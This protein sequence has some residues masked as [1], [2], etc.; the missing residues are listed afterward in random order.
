MR[1][2]ARVRR[3]QAVCLVLAG[4]LAGCVSTQSPQAPGPRS[5]VAREDPLVL[6]AQG[7]LRLASGEIAAGLRLLRRAW[8]LDPDSAE[9]GEELGL[10]LM[11]SG[12]TGDALAVLKSLPARS[13]A[14]EAALGILLVGEATTLDQTQAAVGHLRAGVDAFPMGSQA[15]LTL[16]QALVRL[17]QGEEASEHVRRLL[18]ERPGDPRLHLL[19]GQ[20]LRLQGK[21]EQAIEWYEKA[22]ANPEIRI[23]A[24][25]ELIDAYSATGQFAKAA[26]LMGAFLREGSPTLGALTR[27]ATLLARSG[28]REKAVE[29]VDEVIDKDPNFREGLLLKALFEL[30]DNRMESAERLYRRA[31][32]LDPGDPDARLG[33]GRLL[34]ELRRLD[35]ARTE[36]QKVW[37][38]VS[39]ASGVPSEALADLTRDLAALELTARRPDSARVWLEKSSEGSIGRRALALWSELF[40]QQQAWGEGLEWL[41]NAT[42]D[43]GPELARQRTSTRAEL[44]LAAGQVAAADEILDELFAGDVSD[45]QAGLVALQRRRLYERTAVQAEAA[46]LR[47]PESQQL[48]F[49][50]AAALERSGQW[51]RAVK[52]FRALLAADPEHAPALN[53][54]GYMFADRNMNLD[55][56]REMIAKAVQS[57]PTS[58]AYLD[59]LGWVY[60]RLGDL[61]Q[62]EKYL[63]EAVKL[64][65]FDATLHEHLGDLWV[66]RGQ[67][68]KAID[69][70]RLAL[71]LEH[72]EADQKGRLEAKLK[73]L[74]ASPDS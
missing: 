39:G 45:V 38:M 42:F 19:A 33:L 27:W 71:T 62:A 9:L 63:L 11:D 73:E 70:Y 23:R 30:G 43:E 64:E 6:A 18:E 28:D 22:I 74:G 21:P 4:V 50:L 25:F 31:I 37:E 5:M 36:L 8:E 47:F 54:L 1:A 15:R 26:A 14:G 65:P 46:L 59:S 29:V 32:A 72:E 58:G 35:E 60:F 3:I 10:A 51:E 53:Y 17:D 69:S 48:R 41:A 7:Q 40:R 55:E 12:V 68:E 2:E 16:A 67:V 56:A 57:Y 34:L 44:L 24:T 52:E 20:A 61:D 66:A 49:D 13:P